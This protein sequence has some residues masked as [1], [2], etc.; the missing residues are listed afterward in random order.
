MGLQHVKE[1]EEHL[2]TCLSRTPLLLKDFAFDN[3]WHNAIKGS[4]PLLMACHFGELPSVKRIVESWGVDVN[5]AAPYYN[6][7]IN[8]PCDYGR[9]IVGKATAVYVASYRGHLDIVRYLVNHGADVSAR[10][11]D[12]AEACFDC[13]LTPLYRAVYYDFCDPPL[14]E[15]RKRRTAIVLLLLESGA[16]PSTDAFS[17]SGNP[18]WATG[19]VCGIDAITA[20]INHGMDLNRRVPFTKETILN[21]WARLSYDSTEEES[22]AVA[23][24]LL[25]RGANLNIQDGRGF[26]PIINAAQSRNLAVLDYMLERNDIS[27]KEKIDAMELAGAVILSDNTND[28]PYLFPKAFDYWRKALCL[29]SMQ[30]NDCGP[31]YKIP[32]SVKTDVRIVEWVS[33]DELED[34]IQQRSQHEIQA[35]LV[36]SR[37]LSTRSWDAVESLFGDYRGIFIKLVDQRRF[38]EM[39]NMQWSMLES[40]GCFEAQEKYLWLTTL[41][42]VDNLIQTLLKLQRNDPL[43]NVETITTSLKLILATDQFHLKHSKFPDNNNLDSHINSMVRLISMLANLPQLMNKDS[44]EYLSELVRRDQ[45]RHPVDGRSLLHI[46][47]LQYGQ[48]HLPFL[49][50]LL[51]AGADPDSADKYGNRPLHALA[52]SKSK[53]IDPAARL[54]LDSGA[55][56]GRLNK[57]AQTATDFRKEAIGNNRYLPSTSILGSSQQASAVEENSAED[58][59]FRD[60]DSVPKL[61]YQSG[62]VVRIKGV[63]YSHLPPNLLRFV[64]LQHA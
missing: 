34:V 29:R 8:K 60:Y 51:R 25:E 38:A 36:R 46:A 59:W 32:K 27:R 12:D 28:I 15:E 48:G 61:K 17:P 9:L 26:T 22:L 24:L 11:L 57:E 63:P 40:I 33:S 30:T 4:T 5:L 6:D 18:M 7:P 16:E 3:G 13:G 52:K 10:I 41:I 31:I 56:V 49:R 54:L 55:Y 50:L 21:Y 19:R 1:I 47:C 44:Y 23:Q 35:F 14:D 2:S 53:L 62:R 20:L 45:R 64:E 37:I 39:L 42:I 58:S 43:L